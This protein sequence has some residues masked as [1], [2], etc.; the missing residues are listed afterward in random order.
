MGAS[1]GCPF[2]C[3]SVQPSHGILPSPPL[4]P[5]LPPSLPPLQRRVYISYLD[6][7]HYF[8]PRDM[9]TQIYHEILTAYLDYVRQRGFHTAHIWACPPFKGDDY[10]LHCHPQVRPL[11]PSL[12]PSLP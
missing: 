6:S 3:A 4:P 12:P 5:P 8:R 10:V 9:R 1:P 7:V 11:P 2:Q